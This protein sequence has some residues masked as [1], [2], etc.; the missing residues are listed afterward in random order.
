MITIRDVT[1]SDVIAISVLNVSAFGQTNE[2][3]LVDTLRDQGCIAHELVAVEQ[4]DAGQ[5][6]IIGYICFSK[7]VSPEGW[8]ALAPVSV[9]STRQGHGI[10]GDLIRYGLDRARQDRADAVVVLGDPIYYH[11]F[12]FVFGG[13]AKLTS[14]Y[15]EQFM[16]IYP[17]APVTAA[18]EVTLVYPAPFLEA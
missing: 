18:A 13:P 16:G 7:F 9:R 3:R 6:D 2:A 10:G 15:P 11:R 14:P 4:D 12:G 17:L 1:E 8:L 5:D